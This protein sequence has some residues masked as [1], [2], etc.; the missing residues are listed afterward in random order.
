MPS[1]CISPASYEQ[2]KKKKKKRREKNHSHWKN[3]SCNFCSFIYPS[4][5]FQIAPRNESSTFLRLYLP[6]IY[7]VVY[8]VVIYRIITSELFILL[9]SWIDSFCSP[10]VCLYVCHFCFSFL[11]FSLLTLCVKYLP[12]SSKISSEAHCCCVCHRHNIF[13]LSVYSPPRS[14]HLRCVCL[15]C[16]L[17]SLT[18]IF[19]A[20]LQENKYLFDI[21]WWE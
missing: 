21:L 14:L 20:T 13:F 1:A 15:L 6:L 19:I 7:F 4:I 10:C 16:A 12:L 8:I 9:I 18:F 11:R 2:K 3:D 17:I 5:V